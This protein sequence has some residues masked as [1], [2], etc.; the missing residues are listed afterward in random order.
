MYPFDH[1]EQ[2][3]IR[4][5]WYCWRC[6]AWYWRWSERAW[7]PVVCIISASPTAFSCSNSLVVHCHRA[8]LS[9]SFQHFFFSCGS[10]ITTTLGNFKNSAVADRFVLPCASNRH[11]RRRDVR[12]IF[13]VSLFA[14]VWPDK[15]QSCSSVVM[16]R[17]TTCNLPKYAVKV[18]FSSLRDKA[19]ENLNQSSLT[20]KIF[21]VNLW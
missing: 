9:L 15:V 5:R 6:W 1:L 19:V 18:K 20:Q 16:I 3:R 13:R 8:Y 2:G 11:E 4:R 14:G 7:P 21:L 12:L 17:Y 10:T